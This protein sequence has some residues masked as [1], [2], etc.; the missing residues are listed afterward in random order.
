M[1]TQTKTTP[2]NSNKEKTNVTTTKK[3]RALRV[4]MQANLRE[5]LEAQA[6]AEKTT[7]AQIIRQM[8]STA[9]SIKLEAAARGGSPKK[10]ASKEERV[11][12]S[13]ERRAAKKDLIKELLAAHAAALAAAAKA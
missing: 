9:Y 5:K 8:L 12:A 10:Y 6:K 7:P 13:K 3:V 1:A 2:A 4:P 11:A